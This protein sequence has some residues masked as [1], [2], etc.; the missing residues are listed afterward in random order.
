MKMAKWWII[1]A[2]LSV[3]TVFAIGATIYLNTTEEEAPEPE[4]LRVVSSL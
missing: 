4:N 1:G 2:V 3:A